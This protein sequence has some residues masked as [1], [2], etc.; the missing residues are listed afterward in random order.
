MHSNSDNSSRSRFYQ[1]TD[2][3]PRSSGVATGS[4][5]NAVG[6]ERLGGTTF[7][8]S[9]RRISRS[10]IQITRPTLCE[11]MVD[12]KRAIHL[13]TFSALGPLGVLLPHTDSIRPGSMVGEMLSNKGLET[14]A[15]FDQRER[16]K[17]KSF[18]RLKRQEYAR[19]ASRQV[20][21]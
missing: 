2:V 21:K 12:R 16:K 13:S 20:E 8:G 18:G 15:S 9:T 14:K 6:S 1:S 5:T 10:F 7:A 4:T 19:C 17:K 11:L 3:S